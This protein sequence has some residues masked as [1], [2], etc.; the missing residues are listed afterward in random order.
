MGDHESLWRRLRG[1]GAGGAARRRCL[2][3]ICALLSGAVAASAVGG[4]DVALTSS[5]PVLPSAVAGL[6]GPASGGWTPPSPYSSPSSSPSLAASTTPSSSATAPRSAT[7]RP[8]PTPKPSA[9]TRNKY[10]WPFAATSIWNMPIGSRSLFIPANLAPRTH[11]D[12]A[13]DPDIIV[14]DPTAPMTTIEYSG[15][16][17]SGSNRCP[18]GGTL[19]SAPIP[20]GFTV[21]SDGQNDTLAAVMPDGR[22]VVQGEP[23]A[24]CASGGPA[25]LLTLSPAADLY[26]NGIL[27]GHGGSGLSSFGGAIRLGELVPGGSIRHALAIDLNG[28]TDLFP[29]GYRWPAI[30]HDACA[31]GCYG[32][33]VPALRMGAL[34]ALPTSMSIGSL[35]LETEPGRM[36]AWTLQNYGAYVV[37]DAARSV[38]AVCTEEGPSGSMVAQFQ[39]AWGFPFEAPA[40]TG[41]PWSHDISAIFS[42]LAVVANNGPSSIGG[43]GTPLQPLAPP[44]GN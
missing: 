12:L 37:D 44:I 4:R 36:L 41:T 28:A 2:A 18:G 11:K 43:G 35:G 34:L 26:G 40:G 14:M 39:Q 6:A 19:A 23:F 24:R 32:G 22:T 9:A 8:S 38:F 21:A 16:G 27:G 7:R 31:P 33:T 20:P 5:T 42:H 13:A 3:C 1:G 29:Q 10:V 17:W 30:R 15:A 25:T